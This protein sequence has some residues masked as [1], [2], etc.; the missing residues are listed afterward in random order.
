MPRKRSPN[1]WLGRLSAAGVFVVLF[2]YVGLLLS[3]D[4]NWLRLGVGFLIPGA[5][6]LI[7][8]IGNLKTRRRA[9]DTPT[10]PIASAQGGAAV[11]IKGHIV[12]GKHG[13]L[14]APFSGRAC[15]W[16]SAKVE[17]R[18]FDGHSSQWGRRAS[19]KQSRAFLLDDGSG[20]RARIRPKGATVLVDQQIV[21]SSREHGERPELEEFLLQHGVKSETILGLAKELRYMEAVL[22]PGDFLYALGPSERKPSAQKTND[23]ATT[24]TAPRLVLEAGSGEDEGLLLTNVSEEELATNL[25]G[26]SIFGV[27]MITIGAGSLA[28]W[29]A[30]TRP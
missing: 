13:L 2:A 5:A 12:A 26:L 6:I 8:S 7:V 14:K 30:R 17:E 19:T 27:F 16:F 22:S 18:Y 29:F 1:A 15:V 11:E 21:A 20:E 4:D 25:L 28:I 24:K 9:I 23:R 10:S 3:I